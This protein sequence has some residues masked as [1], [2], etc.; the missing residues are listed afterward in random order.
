MPQ[1]TTKEGN[2]RANERKKKAWQARGYVTGLVDEK[3]QNGLFTAKRMTED[4][5]NGIDKH[6]T[7]PV[8]EYHKMKNWTQ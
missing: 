6:M 5:Q 2:R 7:C 1:F 4:R 8:T 3:I